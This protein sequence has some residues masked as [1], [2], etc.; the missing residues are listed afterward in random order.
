MPKKETGRKVPMGKAE[1]K[2]VKRTESVAKSYEGT[3][4]SGFWHMLLGKRKK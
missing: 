4:A 2:K 1:R 3:G